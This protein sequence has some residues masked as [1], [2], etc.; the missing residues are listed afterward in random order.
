MNETALTWIIFIL[1]FGGMIIL[2]ELGHFIA[3]RLVKVEVEEFGIGLPTPGA[4]T[5]FTWQGTRFTLNWLPL[6]G[7]VRPKG[8]N[9]PNVEGGLAAAAPW[10]RLVVLFA[11][12]LMNLATAVIIIGIII[13]QMGGIITRNPESGAQ[14]ILITEVVPN[15]PADQ[16][17]LVMGDILLKGGDQ[18]L[19]D[20]LA[21]ESVV[22]TNVDI[23]TAYVVLRDGKEIVLDITSRMNEQAGRPMIGIAFCSGCE[24]QPITSFPQLAQYSLSVTGNQIYLL[25]TLP[26][27]LIQGSIPAEQGRLVG[28]K[29]IFDIMGQSV[30]N[31]VEVARTNASSPSTGSNPFNQPV[32]TLF[33]LASLSISLGIFNLFP[34]PALD[35]GRIVFVLPELIFRRRVPHE[36]ENLVHGLGM[37]FLLLVMIYVNV[38]DFIDPV[39]DMFP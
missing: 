19:I 35:G 8:E 7:F 36:F 37:T 32:S 15:S 13:N 9:D 30:S 25:T 4:I 3:A 18:L 5:L 28:L 6:G 33:I 11:G 34:F 39:T 38:K 14:D 29:G 1:A 31:D 17:G 21:L 16:A 2:H 24:F 22:T 26:I 20:D 10:K 12:P 23:P 27:R